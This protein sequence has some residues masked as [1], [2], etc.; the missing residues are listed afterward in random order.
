MLLSFVALIIGV[1]WYATAQSTNEKA[2]KISYALYVCGLFVFLFQAG[3]V[4]MEL[5]NHNNPK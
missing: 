1:V 4:L 3:P 5:V 2:C